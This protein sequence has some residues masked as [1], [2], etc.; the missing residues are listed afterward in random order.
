MAAKENSYKVIN[1][2][3][4]KVSN[5]KNIEINL[6]YLEDAHIL[7]RNIIFCDYLDYNARELE[8]YIRRL[9]VLYYSEETRFLVHLFLDTN[10]QDKD[11]ETITGISSSTIGR[12]LNPT[13]IS[14]SKPFESYMN[15]F[16]EDWQFI[17]DSVVKKRQENLRQA[18]ERGGHVS[19]L[20]NVF[21]QDEKGFFR[22]SVKLRLDL[23]ANNQDLQCKILA[24][25][26]NY[27]HLNS[28]TL[29]NL[30]GMEEA[31]VIDILHNINGSIT[32]YDN[33]ERA[34]LEF[35]AFYLDYCKYKN[36][37]LDSSAHLLEIKGEIKTLGQIIAALEINSQVDLN[38]G[39]RNV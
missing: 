32:M 17:Y 24:N 13:G 1:D 5:L 3:C 12:R 36:N 38:V 30:F 34:I 11:L 25:I 6:G 20:N 2:I 9:K 10:L 27:F 21:I 35:K 39:S 19:Q 28:G 4:K 22:G 8:A 18:K 29:A 33:Q 16:G 26:A 37:E 23:F 14:N 31:E 7:E 15:A